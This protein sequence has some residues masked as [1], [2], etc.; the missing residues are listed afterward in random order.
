MVCVTKELGHSMLFNLFKN[1]DLFVF[2]H[3]LVFS[4]HKCLYKSVGTPGAGD[5]DSYELP[6][7]F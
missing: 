1:N 5:I 7:G 3:A 4:L 2:S 6:F